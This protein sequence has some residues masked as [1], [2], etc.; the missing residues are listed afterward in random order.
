MTLALLD[1]KPND[2]RFPVG[3]LFCAGARRDGSSYCDHHHRI[4]YP[5]KVGG[6]RAFSSGA[7]LADHI[8]KIAPA[9]PGRAHEIVRATPAPVTPPLLD[10]FVRA[11]RA[12]RHDAPERVPPKPK[13]QIAAEKSDADRRE[14]ERQNA[15]RLAQIK[16]LFL[17]VKT[18]QAV[19]NQLPRIM[20]EVAAKHGVSTEDIKSARRGALIVQARQEFFY[21]ARH[22][23]RKSYPEISKFCGGRDHTSGIWA[24]RQH[25]ARLSGKRVTRSCHARKV[26]AE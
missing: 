9:R 7:F 10:Q 12:G 5:V 14:I 11:A 6:G 4:A 17:A 20:T 26:A 22:E 19:V 1:L 18:P 3:D 2:C 13:A 24:V 8:E 16:M 21:R 23:T 25:E 15:V